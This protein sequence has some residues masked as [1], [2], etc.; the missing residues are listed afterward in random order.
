MMVLSLRLG[1]TGSGDEVG[2]GP[3]VSAS[4]GDA[5]TKA[6]AKA[7]AK[8]AMRVATKPGAG[9]GSECE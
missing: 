7:A 5:P 4:H 9:D 2:D 1:V 8:A 3:E 6:A